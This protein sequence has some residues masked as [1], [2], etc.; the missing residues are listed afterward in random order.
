MFN[1]LRDALFK[2]YYSAPSIIQNLF[3]TI[4]G[5]KLYRERFNRNS[6]KYLELLKKTE[7][8]SQAEM[9][10]FVDEQFVA[11]ARIAI[12]TVPFYKRWAEDNKIQ[13][14]DI[15][16]ISD[17]WRFPIIKKSIVRDNPRDFISDLAPHLIKL[18][19]SGTTGSPLDIYC[20]KDERTYHYAFFSRMRSWFGLKERS[21]RATFFGRI[22]MLPEQ[23]RPP[24]WRMDL[25]QNNLLMSSYHMST[26]NL[27]CYYRKLLKYKPDEIIG[28]P[29]SLYE[30][31]RYIIRK[32]LKPIDCKVVITTA[33]TLLKYQREALERAFKAPVID[34][35]GCT[36]MA[37]FVSQCEFGTMH[38]HPEHGYLETIGEEGEPVKDVPGTLLATG[39]V[40]RSMP[41]IRYE[42]GDRIT[43]SSD[44]PNCPCGRQFP[45]VCNV[46][47]RIDDV[48]FRKDGTPVGRLDPVFKGGNGIESAKIE[49][50][51]LGDI[52]VYV[53]ATGSFGQHEHEWLRLE[54]EKRLGTDIE[55]SIK[56]VKTMEKQSNGKFKS[57]ESNYRPRNF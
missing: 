21:K 14:S 34:Q 24:F 9:K 35:Y 36:E 41:L 28:Y 42:V 29:S 19:T 57:V 16:G 49:Q 8:F 17:I 30:L 18:S 40:N 10:R 52:T 12:E 3:V 25:I 47:G 1:V 33:E 32:D 53:L 2:V 26:P 27:E 48:I 54:L 56:L 11:L 20:S 39:L 23:Q 37:F 51:Y 44:F 50:D 31:A 22:I 7:T 6:K 5:Y 46:E 55:I 4:Y 15:T 13:I 45:V 38:S 43:L